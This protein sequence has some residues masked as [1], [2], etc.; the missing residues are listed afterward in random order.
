MPISL[1]INNNQRQAALPI[2][3]DFFIL[4]MRRVIGLN[5]ILPI[6]LMWV[7]LPFP[8]ILGIGVVGS[9]F[10][11][12]VIAPPDN[13]NAVLIYPTL[14]PIASG[15]GMAAGYGALLG[16]LFLS[17]LWVSGFLATAPTIILPAL[18][19]VGAIGAAYVAIRTGSYILNKI[20][21]GLAGIW[22]SAVV[23]AQA[24][25]AYESSNSHANEHSAVE[26][27]VQAPLLSA[28]GYGNSS[29]TITASLSAPPS[30]YP[31]VS[32]VNGYVETARSDEPSQHYVPTAPNVS[33]NAGHYEAEESPR[34]GGR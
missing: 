8:F 20:T 34:P 14:F 7:G 11:G 10:Y 5:F 4:H 2:P 29:A 17:S 6:V 25:V 32:P 19:T 33:E 15:L 26:S 21:D 3:V 30:A 9:T 12:V 13:G 22:R 16:A 31:T 23:E 28:N 18:I 1:D 27:Q 24:Q